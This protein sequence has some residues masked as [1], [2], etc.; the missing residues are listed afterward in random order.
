MR[1]E[2]TEFLKRFPD[3][4]QVDTFIIDLCGNAMGKRFPVTDLPKLY[5]DGSRICASAYLL[6]ARGN[7]SD[8]LGLGFSDGDPDAIMKPVP[9]TLVPVPWIDE[10][11]AQCLMQLQRPE[12]G[13][14]VWFEPRVIL[15]TVLDKFTALELTPVVAIELEFYL[16]DRERDDSGLPQLPVSPFSG[17]RSSAGQVY[18]FDVLEEFSDVF[19]RI[20]AACDAQN[21]PATVASSEYGVGQ[22]ELNLKHTNDI[23]RACDWAAMQRRAIKGACRAAG[24]DATFLSK[25]FAGESGSGQH[26]H[27]SLRDD[28]GRPVFDPANPT[29]DDMIRYA[30]AGMQQTLHEAML[31][32]APNLN[33]FRRFEPDQFV[34]VTRDWGIDNRS[35]AF[36][37]VDYDNKNRRIEH[38][39]AGAEANPYLVVA[40][41]LAGI[42]HGISNRLE[43]TDMASG[44]AGAEVDESLPLIIWQAIEIMRS[45]Q[46]L[47]Q[48][49]SDDYIDAYTRVK[50]GEFDEFMSAMSAQELDWYL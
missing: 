7:S 1:D 20:H 43:P 28:Q 46:V 29:S 3:T 25:P 50:Q 17:R 48:Y 5:E 26:I 10:P 11:R 32:F 6:D 22:F 49:L 4:K 14:P 12:T 34:P 15:Q 40:A 16:L 42:H 2:V 41:V 30:V 19:A 9:G 36:R 27:V 33:A 45:A 8:P 23:L 44:N 13:D 38:R 24:F 35:M 18:G 47:P 21:I 37:V 31:V 39:V